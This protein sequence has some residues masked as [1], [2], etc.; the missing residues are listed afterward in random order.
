MAHLNGASD[1][2][3]V[4]NASAFTACPTADPGFVYLDMLVRAAT[5]A[6]LVR[7]DHSGAQFVEDLKGRIVTRGP[8]C[9]WNWT[10]DMPG[11]WLAT[12]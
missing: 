11:V 4:V 10:A 3:L 2:N 9:R 7:A 8:S 1:Q 12:R 5:D 6:I